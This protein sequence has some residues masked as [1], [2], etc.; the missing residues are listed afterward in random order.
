MTHLVK[1]G[2]LTAM[3]MVEKMSYNPAKIL[4]I[5]RGSLQ[6]GKIADI[7]I[8]DPDEEYEIDAK[9]FY[10]KGKNTPFHGAK[11]VGKIKTTLLAGEVVFEKNQFIK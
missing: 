5:D 4:G 1:P 8:A 2:H 7:V 11:V 10:S 9:R 3:Q 6:V